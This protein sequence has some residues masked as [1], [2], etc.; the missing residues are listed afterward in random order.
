MNNDTK[1][2]NS[3]RVWLME[4]L[5]KVVRF[6]RY[7]TCRCQGYCNIHKNAIL[8]SNL[9]LDRVYPQGIHIGP[10][11]LVASHTKIL[12]HD[13]C[14]RVEGLPFTSETH[15][16]RNCFIAVGAMVLPGITIGDE[17][18]VGAGAVVTKDV[19]SNSIVAGNPARIIRQGIRMN[20]RAELMD[21]SPETGHNRDDA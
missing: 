3:R 6:L 21:W 13:H 15:I 11:T 9:V 14:K 20:D 18:I 4:S 12:S 19:P 1:K 5:S 16:G 10:N 17:V 7:Y 2:K 8:E